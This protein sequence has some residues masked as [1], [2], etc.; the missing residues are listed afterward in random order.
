MFQLDVVI[1][2]YNNASLLDRTLDFLGR[3]QAGPGIEWRVLIV[4]NHD[5]RRRYFIVDNT[6]FFRRT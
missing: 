5:F 1:C 3:Q 4:D 6:A 2:T